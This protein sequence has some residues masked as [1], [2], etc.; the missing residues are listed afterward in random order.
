MLFRSLYQRATFSPDANHRWMGSVA[1]DRNGNMLMGYSVSGTGIHPAI[2]YTGRLASDA[3]N[4]MQAETTMFA[5]TGSQTA[6]LSRWGDYAAMTVDPA[7]DCTFW[8]TT[9]YFSSTNS[10][11]W[12]TRIGS[13]KFPNCGS[14]PT[15]NNGADLLLS[16]TSSAP[17]VT[18]GDNIT[19]TLTLT[20]HGPQAATGVTLTDTLPA[21]VNF[22]SASPNNCQQAN[23]TVTCNVGN[24][25][26]S[27]PTTVTIVVTTTATGTLTNTASAQANQTDPNTS[28]NMA[29]ATTTA[30]DP[31]SNVSASAPTSVTFSPR[32]NRP[33]RRTVRITLFNDGTTSVTIKNITTPVGAPFSITSIASPRLPTTIAAGGKKRFTLNAERA[34]G[35]SSVTVDPLNY[36]TDRKSV[37]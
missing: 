5:G 34:A 20:N 8:F 12:K 11:D 31:C 29:V 18:V 24:L 32:A 2:R 4:T 9:E 25:D 26:V 21:G 17:T 37:V 7:D 3:L 14:A 33:A 19:Y 1:M 10:G 28:N 30:N 22:V 6:S 16:N 27:I 15:N 36:L 35:L 13:F 23:G